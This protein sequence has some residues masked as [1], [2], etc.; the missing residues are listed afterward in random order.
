MSTSAK[1]GKGTTIA[2]TDAGS[3]S[4]DL[5]IGEIISF[6]GPGG[7]GE[8]IDATHLGSTAKEKLMGLPDEGQ[9]SFECNL[10]DG[11]A[12]QALLRTR[13]DDQALDAFKITLPGSEILTFNAYVLG[14]KVAGGVDEV[15]RASVT[16]EI[17]GAVTWA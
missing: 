1:T 17:S 8:V 14:F 4:G 13:R 6:D 9:L 5:S 16:L 10:V 7:E 12:G 11:D 2:F 15:V 3:P